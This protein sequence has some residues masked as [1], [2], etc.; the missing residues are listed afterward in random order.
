M[1]TYPLD[2]D[3]LAAAAGRARRSAGDDAR[4]LPPIDEAERWLRGRTI[5]SLD[6]TGAIFGAAPEPPLVARVAARLV[7]LMAE[8]QRRRDLVARIA[9]ARREVA[10]GDDR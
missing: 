10:R 2:L 4:W 9:A 8:E 5:V 3:A 7:V 1:P 6:D